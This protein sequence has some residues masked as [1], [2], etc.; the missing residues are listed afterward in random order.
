MKISSFE[1][2]QQISHRLCA[3]VSKTK[4]TISVCCGTGCRASASLNVINAFKEEL[5]RTNLQSTILLKETGCH[6]FCEKGPLVVIY[7]E[8]I[9]YKSVTAK[10]VPEI[11]S[12]TIMNG[13]VVERLLYEE[14]KNRPRR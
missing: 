8:K 2:L 10:D 3:E 13:K 9:F 14:E 11:L 4:R 12:E 7:P 5:E 1:E 6:G